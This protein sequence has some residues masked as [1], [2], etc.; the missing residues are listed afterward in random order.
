[1]KKCWENTNLLLTKGWE[2][3]KTGQTG[4]AGSCLSSLRDGIFI[5][6]LNCKDNE[7]RFS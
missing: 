3:I 1:M 6:V 2:G 5:V 4:P 7:A